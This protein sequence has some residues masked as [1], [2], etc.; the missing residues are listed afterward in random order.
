MVEEVDD[1]DETLAADEDN[2]L[3]IV[4]S[5]QLEVSVGLLG[6]RILSLLMISSMV[7]S[8]PSVLVVPKVDA[9]PMVLP[10]RMLQLR[11]LLF[12]AHSCS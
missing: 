7:F 6:G 4:V 11:M 9:L 3:F 8:I 12:A 2:G 5:S 10:E 1:V